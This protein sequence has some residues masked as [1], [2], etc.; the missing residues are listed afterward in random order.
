MGDIPQLGQVLGTDSLSLARY[1]LRVEHQ[2][3]L[4]WANLDR[5]IRGNNVDSY[6]LILGGFLS[7]TVFGF[8]YHC[9]IDS[10]DEFIQICSCS[11]RMLE[12]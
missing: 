10:D 3:D 7:R 11:F 12:I 8:R 5:V 1:L 4:S 6:A 2:P 9:G